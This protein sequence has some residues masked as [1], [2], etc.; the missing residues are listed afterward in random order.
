MKSAFSYL[1][2]LSSFATVSVRAEGLL[3]SVSN[4][5]VNTPNVLVSNCLPS[6]STSEYDASRRLLRCEDNLKTTTAKLVEAGFV[7]LSVSP[8]RQTQFS[9]LPGS[10]CPGGNIPADTFGSVAFIR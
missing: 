6:S 2:V 5:V 9:G 3:D 7:I 1:F 4:S 8:C 10:Y